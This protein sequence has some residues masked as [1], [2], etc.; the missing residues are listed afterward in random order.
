M[1]QYTLKQ[2]QAYAKTLSVNELM[3]LAEQFRNPTP[4]TDE[5]VCRDV[6]DAEVERRIYNWEMTT[7]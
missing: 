3:A 7:A 5:E 2:R 4:G 1:K 6:V